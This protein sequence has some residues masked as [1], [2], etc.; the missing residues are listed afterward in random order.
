VVSSP[1][2]PLPE[3]SPQ[4]LATVSPPPPTP[5]IDVLSPPLEAALTRLARMIRAVG[6]RHGLL[7]Q[8]LDALLQDVRIRVWRAH[9]TGESIA[10]LPTSYVY[11]VAMTAAVDLVRKRR[12]EHDR[13]PA[14]EEAPSAALASRVHTDE[15]ALASD[16]GDAIARAL[17]S[18]IEARRV[19]VRMHLIGYE[20]S[21]MSALLGWSDDK[22]RNLLYRGLQDLRERL[23]HAGYRWPEDG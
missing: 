19:V 13:E 21:E 17:A 11:R 20:R 23:T 10:Q 8:D 15:A 16:L 22:V 2:P 18:M 6:A 9:P 14:I 12:R 7:D 1:Q 3:P 4:P 5:G